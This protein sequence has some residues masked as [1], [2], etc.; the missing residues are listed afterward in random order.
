MQL[1]SPNRPTSRFWGI[2]FAALALC[3]FIWG[4][5]YKLS[6][7]DPPQAASHHVPM[8]KL[9]SKSEQSNTTEESIYAQSDPT[10]KSLYSVS[11]VA[12]FS[13]LIVCVFC[14]PGLNHCERV[15]NPSL[16]LQQALLES[17]FV[18][19]PPVLT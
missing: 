6:L 13:L 15:Q 4:L 5:Q 3:V 14:P 17:F 11:N 8:A 18:R 10:I 1:W 12:L 2:L 19:P 16:P 9:L 7:Y